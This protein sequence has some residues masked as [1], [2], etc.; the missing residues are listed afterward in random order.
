LLPITHFFIRSYVR[1][2]LTYF[3][4]TDSY[5]RQLLALTHAGPLIRRKGTGKDVTSHIP[6]LVAALAGIDDRFDIPGFSSLKISGLVALAV[7]NPSL[8]GPQLARQFFI[9]DYGLSQRAGL[10]LAI[11][12]AARELSGLS[13]PP[14]ATVPSRTPLPAKSAAVWGAPPEKEIS[15]LTTSLQNTLLTPMAA[16][17]ADKLTG[18]AILKVR[19]FSSRMAVEARRSKAQHRPIIDV[20]ANA[21]FFPLT[22]GWWVAVR[23]GPCISSPPQADPHILSLLIETL[24]LLTYAVGPFAPTLPQM[25]AEMIQFLLSLRRA[26]DSDVRICRAIL[27]GL[28][29]VLEIN[30]DNSS[31]DGSRKLAETHA[32][33]VVEIKEWVEG[34]F[35]GPYATEE[36]V[37]SVA[38]GVLVKISEIA[39]TYRKTLMSQ[40][41]VIE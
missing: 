16:S 14:T 6:E 25:T 30:G 24:A 23:E 27:V 7:T 41:G 20:A 32:G 9:G 4:A 1:D 8:T 12:L 10:L 28:L 3:H 38:A 2:L 5:D 35:S 17:A 22:G 13:D 18:P 11:G 19:I 39:E 37:K 29:T 40:I 36:E 26:A 21:F 34:I 15:R 33:E 31:G